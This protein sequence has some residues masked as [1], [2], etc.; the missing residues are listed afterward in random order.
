MVMKSL[1]SSPKQDGFFMPPEY[2][3]HDGTL[4]LMPFRPDVWR[5]N[6]KEAQDVFLKIAEAISEFE[7]V[8]I[9]VHPTLFPS[10]KDKKI[11]N[12]TFFECV[13]DDAWMRDVGPTFLKNAQG[14]IRA[15]DWAF[16]AYGG[17]QY[18]L[19]SPWNQ[20]DAVAKTV[21]DHFEIDAYRL[22]D[23]VMEGGA[24]HVDEN[25]L[26]LVTEYNL[27][28]PGRNPNLTKEKIEQRLLEALGAKKIIW[29]PRGIYN[30]ETRE[31]VDNVATFIGPGHVLLAYA[32]DVRDAQQPLSER[33]MAALQ[34]ATDLEGKPLK[35]STI[36]MP[37]AI[38]RTYFESA[39]LTQLEK[40]KK[41]PMNE[42]LA[43]SYLNLY[44]VNGGVIVPQFNQKFDAIAYEQLKL[45]FPDRKVVMI[46]SKEVLL[47][48]GNIH[49]ITQQMPQGVLNYG[50]YKH[51]SRPHSNGDV[52]K[53]KG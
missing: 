39:A 14:D 40:S 12:I 2:G 38:H 16:N 29:L 25:G 4:M 37:K 35:I 44:L 52:A 23:F 34:A 15:V 49:C 30:D 3:P 28:H 42:R 46:D 24:F 36:T 11:P 27:L 21:C 26:V 18:G 41:R 20:D 48:G 5:N 53:S 19:Y 17:H 1:K 6:A 7:P 33:T 43:A 8:F 45:V 51:Q 50:P 31:H 47:G 32:T 22:D 10:Y 9:G 13:S